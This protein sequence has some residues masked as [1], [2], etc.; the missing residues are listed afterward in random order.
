[1]FICIIYVY[2]YVCSQV[3]VMSKVESENL[4]NTVLDVLNEFMEERNNEL[5]KNI[6]K[7]SESHELNEICKN[8]TEAEILL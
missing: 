7:T 8:K 5:Q 6:K 3:E 1:M 4:G 2:I